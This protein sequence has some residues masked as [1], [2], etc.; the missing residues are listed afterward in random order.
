MMNLV[1]VE[2]RPNPTLAVVVATWFSFR[3]YGKPSIDRYNISVAQVSEDH[4]AALR[5]ICSP[6]PTWQWSAPMAMRRQT[7]QKPTRSLKSVEISA[8]VGLKSERRTDGGCPRARER[9]REREK[10]KEMVTRASLKSCPRVSSFCFFPDPLAQ[11]TFWIKDLG[12]R[13]GWCSFLPSL[14]R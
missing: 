2:Q 1:P 8:A 4:L 13:F 6:R 5:P 10:K 3:G 11:K 12:D 14:C 9:E 7:K